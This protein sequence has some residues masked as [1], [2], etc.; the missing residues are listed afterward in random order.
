MKILS[1]IQNTRNHFN[2]TKPQLIQSVGALSDAS[3][4]IRK[5]MKKN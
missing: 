3:E 1:S 4:K 5:E 2:Y